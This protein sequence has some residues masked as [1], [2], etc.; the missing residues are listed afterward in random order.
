MS[1]RMSRAP[2]GDLIAAFRRMRV[3]VVGDLYIDEY[4]QGRLVGVSP[5]MPVPR[6]AECTRTHQLG[7][8]GNVA[9]SFAAMGAT[10]SMF[11]VIG[12]D[13]E[14]DRARALLG[15]AGIDASGLQQ[16]AGR[17]TGTFTRFLAGPGRHYLRLDR[18]NRQPIGVRLRA[19]L[20]ERI[21]GRLH[22]L[23]LLY[24][25]DYDET[26]ERSGC[27]SPDL[28]RALVAAAGDRG[29]PVAASSRLAPAVFAGTTY[30]F[31][32]R[33]EARGLGW[34]PPEPLGAWMTVTR[35]ALGVSL[36]V[37]TEGEAGLTWTAGDDS[38]TVP[39]VPA[40][41]VD[42]CGAGDALAAVMALA[43]ASGSA[44]GH[45]ARLGARAAAVAIGRA[46]TVPVTWQD[47]QASLAVPSG[48]TA[49]SAAA[50]AP[51]VTP[52]AVRHPKF[53]PMAEMA[54]RLAPFRGSARIVFTNGCFDLLHA[55]HVALLE[56]A[57]R[58][59][60]LLVVGINSDRSTRANKGPGRPVL[61]EED[62]VAILTAL[63]AVDLVTVFDELT[64]I[65]LIR[66][67]GPDVLVKGGDYTED[68]VV[69]RDLV[70]AAGGR[71]VV[72][73]YQRGWNTRTLIQSL[74]T[75]SDGTR[76]G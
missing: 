75:A 69:G 52:T 28:V 34:A 21:A 31:C 4:V 76:A 38:G 68:E 5:E 11:A 9:A 26:P 39:A 14:G 6:L 74:R 46:G 51:G 48:D 71:V 23:D 7:A 72:F 66:Q 63:E 55:G 19:R 70:E 43:L 44:P 16:D 41:V 60:D 35:E 22:D 65:R 17:V 10:V 50:R 73:P 61:P 32:N 25:S 54:D 45:A 49:E 58:E 27:V 13:A 8:A 64:P 20:L 42:P 36:L 53:V 15:D 1:A 18:E 29:L 59:G 12:Q 67:I 33:A 3:G 2:G 56:A 37:V 62:R 30:L 57:R 40:A 47:L 24:L